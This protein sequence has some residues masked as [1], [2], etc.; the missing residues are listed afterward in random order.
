MVRSPPVEGDPDEPPVCDVARC[1][2]EPLWEL[3]D[4]LDGRA[5]WV[6]IDCKDELGSRTRYGLVGPLEPPEPDE[7]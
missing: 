6:C 1:D 2:Q 3:H 5:L 7:R 4:R